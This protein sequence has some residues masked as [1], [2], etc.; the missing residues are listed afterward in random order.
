MFKDNR[1]FPMFEETPILYL[2]FIGSS[3]PRQ[4][5]ENN[6]KLGVVLPTE[7]NFKQILMSDNEK[8]VS[9]EHLQPEDNQL[10][11]GHLSNF[12]RK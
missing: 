7:S 11:V 3:S 9:A 10:F 8:S 5:L 12:Q 6:E 2:S 1:L 4:N